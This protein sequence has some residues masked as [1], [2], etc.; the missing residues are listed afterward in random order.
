ME[1]SS[2]S[3]PQVV[4]SKRQ[5]STVAVPLDDVALFYKWN[6]GSTAL[7]YG[8]GIA[9]AVLFVSGLWVVALTGGGT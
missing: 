9:A 2:T 8:V 4:C 3:V 6:P 1:M 7:A 5:P